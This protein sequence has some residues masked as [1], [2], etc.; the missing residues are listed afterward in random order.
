MEALNIIIIIS[1]I[2]FIQPNSIP[3]KSDILSQEGK[4]R[5]VQEKS[6]Y[7]YVGIEKCASVCHNTEDMGFQYDVMKNGPHSQ[8]F[9][10]LVS[11]KA[12][13]YAKKVHLKENPQE[14]SA[15]LKCHITGGDL[16]ST[17][18]GVTYKKDD[19]VTC[20]ACHKREFITKSFLPRESDCLKCHNNSVHKVNKFNFT[21]KCVKIAHPRRTAKH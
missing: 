5:S 2:E 17:Y 10:I 11:E 7:K 9:K 19:G 8:A 12:R 3:E 18:F 1:A 20:E 15:C 6:K 14:S 4:S 13:H 16:D 21:D